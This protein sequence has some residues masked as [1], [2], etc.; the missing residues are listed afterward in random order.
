M[1][2]RTLLGFVFSVFTIVN[3]MYHLHVWEKLADKNAYVIPLF[4][5][6]LTNLKSIVVAE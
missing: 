1:Y 2:L 5:D 4:D 3:L 6:I